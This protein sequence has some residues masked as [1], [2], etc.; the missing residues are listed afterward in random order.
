MHFE[1]E[2]SDSLTFFASVTFH[3]EKSIPTIWFSRVSHTTTRR[4][5]DLRLVRPRCQQFYGARTFS[6]LSRLWNNLPGEI[7]QSSLRKRTCGS[8]F[9]L[10]SHFSGTQHFIDFVSK[11]AN[12]S[13]LWRIQ[14]VFGECIMNRNFTLSP[15]NSFHPI[16]IYSS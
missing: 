4:S 8:I 16:S 9:F 5:S 1:V 14:S 13:L 7:P 3:K 2:L 12:L 10:N 11:F 15:T 6:A